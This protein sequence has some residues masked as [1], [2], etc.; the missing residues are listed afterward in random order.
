MHCEGQEQSG[1]RT[2]KDQVSSLQVYSFRAQGTSVRSDYMSSEDW[3]LLDRHLRQIESRTQLEA[4]AVYPNSTLF[5]VRYGFALS[6][7]T[8][9]QAPPVPPV[10]PVIT[11]R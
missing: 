8:H 10:R 4:P 5:R 3:S 11:V 7:K 9:L 1:N 6:R 2:D